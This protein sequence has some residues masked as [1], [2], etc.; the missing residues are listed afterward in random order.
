[1][2]S[3]GQTRPSTKQ[4]ESEEIERKTREFLKQGG[5]IDQADLRVTKCVD[6]HFR[7]YSKAAMEDVR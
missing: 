1:M 4:A 2:T 7:H 6:L 3:I 5:K